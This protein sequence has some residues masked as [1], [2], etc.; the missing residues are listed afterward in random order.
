MLLENEEQGLNKTVQAQIPPRHHTLLNIFCTIVLENMA[1][2]T[3]K[4]LALHSQRIVLKLLAAETAFSILDGS[5]LK[6][7][8]I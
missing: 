8:T 6:A 2:Y 7:T 3:C 4:Y 1:S 5:M